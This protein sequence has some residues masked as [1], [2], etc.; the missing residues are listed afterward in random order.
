MP[1]DDTPKSGLIKPK[2]IPDERPWRSVAK[3]IT[4]RVIGTLDTFFLSAV[5][6]KYLGPWLGMDAHTSNAEIA[7]L[8]G[9]IAI[10]EVV[11]KIVIYT[12][13]ERLWAHLTWKVSHSK[14]KRNESYWRTTI[15]TATWRVIASL[16]TV[17]LAW[18]FTGNFKVAFSVGSFEV[19]TKLVLYFIHER[20]WNKIPMGTR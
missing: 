9:Y 12:L 1:K 3:A 11:T 14:G 13:H 16:D 2:S 15:K 10:T 4:W 8:A 5:I 20:I 6:I 18:F 19:F 7:T 17:F